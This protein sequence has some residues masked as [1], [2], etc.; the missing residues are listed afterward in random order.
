M[1]IKNV[2]IKM[3]KGFTL[4]ELMITVAI[5]GILAAVALPA[6][7]DYT[8]R[9]QVSEAFPLAD[10]VKTAMSEYYAQNG[11]FPATH[12]TVGLATAG[13][14]GKYVGA[15]TSSVAVIS[16]AMGSATPTNSKIYG[17]TLTMTGADAAS[18][19]VIVWTCAK[20]TLPQKY[21]PSSCN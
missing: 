11:A 20:G 3:Q 7:Q 4:I 5:V 2:G 6:Y 17:Q 18:D 14:K 10:G 12:A 13:V 16:V 15:I 21:L 9:A 1:R 8:I 19:G